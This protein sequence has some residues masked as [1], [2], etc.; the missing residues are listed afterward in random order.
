MSEP[1]GP[2]FFCATL[3]INS[4]RSAVR[5]LHL[6]MEAFCGSDNLRERLP[7]VRL[8]LLPL[9]V[10]EFPEHMREHFRHLMEDLPKS[11]EAY[12]RDAKRVI[13]AKTLLSLYTKAARLD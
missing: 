8:Q 4:Q 9:R 10:E 6:A 7:A 13:L 12:F 11:E 2:S 5:D 1:T 3:S